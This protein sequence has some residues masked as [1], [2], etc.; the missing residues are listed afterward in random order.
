MKRELAD[1]ILRAC[2]NNDFL[3]FDLGL[4]LP[5]LREEYKSESGIYV[6][7]EEPSFAIV[8]QGSVFTVMAAVAIESTGLCEDYETSVELWEISQLSQDPMGTSSVIY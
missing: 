7:H 6:S 2:E 3:F 4:A 8:F 5:E 1:F